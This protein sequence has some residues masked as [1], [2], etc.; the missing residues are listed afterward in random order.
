MHAQ[1]PSP[2]NTLEYR[3]WVDPHVCQFVMRV[4]DSIS[5]AAWQQIEC[6]VEAASGQKIAFLCN[7]GRHRSVVC[8]MHA[9]AMWGDGGR[10]RLFSWPEVASSSR[11]G[12]NPL[13]R[14]LSFESSFSGCAWLSQGV[15]NWTSR[16]VVFWREIRRVLND[17]RLR[18]ERR[19]LARNPSGSAQQA[20]QLR[21]AHVLSALRPRWPS[22]KVDSPFWLHKWQKKQNLTNILTCQPLY[23]ARFHCVWS[24]WRVIICSKC[25]WRHHP[26]IFLSGIIDYIKNMNIIY[27]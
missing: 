18:A 1:R 22:R 6:E 13:L 24:L 21:D 15:Y 19:L 7:A 14:H 9:A 16:G 26:Y 23:C 3:T 2:A 10:V 11:S 20:T 4:A 5:I 17:A 12:Q 25:Y 27:K 8:A